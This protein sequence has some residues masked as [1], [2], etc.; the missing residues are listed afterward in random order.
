MLIDTIKLA[1]LRNEIYKDKLHAIEQRHLQAIRDLIPVEQQSA[2]LSL[3]KKKCNELESICEG[4]FLLKELTPRT[5]DSIMSYGEL[6]SSL[7]IS[8][9]FTALQMHHHWIDAREII[10]TWA[11]AFTRVFTMALPMIPVPPVIT[12]FFS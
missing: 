2:I 5:L 3:V 4:V 1:A 8:A 6:L 11:P 10:R 12:T 7:I 9:K